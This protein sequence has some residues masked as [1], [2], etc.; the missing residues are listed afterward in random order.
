M[1]RQEVQ[2]AIGLSRTTIY[3]RVKAGTFPEPVRLGARSVG[4]RVSDIEA[5]LESP[6]DYR[7]SRRPS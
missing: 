5:F 2:R 3:S 6:A 1:R 4:W 7:A